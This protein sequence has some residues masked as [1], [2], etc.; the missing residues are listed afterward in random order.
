MAS[1]AARCWYQEPLVWFLIAI[2]LSSVLVG[3]VVLWFAIDSED[4]LVVD[5]YYKRGLTINKTLDRDVAA[6]QYALDSTINFVRE[7][8][9]IHLVLDANE[10]FSYPS[11]VRL[12]LY[13][14]TK[15]GFDR[16][17]KLT[18]IS[19][20]GYSGTLP[21]LVEGRWY[22]TLFHEHWRLTG[23][24]VWPVDSAALKFLPAES[25]L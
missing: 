8:D 1:T 4:G 18:R 13:H 23:V 22:I 2:P 16:E 19:D 17:M 21:E 24:M 6:R 7:F 15:A 25:K 3:L 5:D 20:T 11:E 14:A 9:Q 12:G 10:D